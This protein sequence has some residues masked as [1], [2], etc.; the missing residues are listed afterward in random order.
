[1]AAGVT[2]LAPFHFSRRYTTNPLPLYEEISE[3]CDRLCAPLSMSVFSAQE[4]QSIL[5]LEE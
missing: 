4:S 1:M 3:V 5:E 2:R